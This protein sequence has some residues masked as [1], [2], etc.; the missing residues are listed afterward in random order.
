MASKNKTHSGGIANK[1][2]IKKVPS[3]LNVTRSNAL[4]AKPKYNY[5]SG[6]KGI[7]KSKFSK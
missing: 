2:Q 5:S 7:T 4:T 1:G 3:R 6:G